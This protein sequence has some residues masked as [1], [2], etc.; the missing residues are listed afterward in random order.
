MDTEARSLGALLERR[1][2]RE[3]AT[4]ESENGGDALRAS[5]DPERR[6]SAS[7]LLTDARKTGNFLRQF[8]VGPGR[9]V[10]IADRPVPESVLA[11]FGTG[12]L[13]ATARFVRLDAPDAGPSMWVG[14]RALVAPTEVVGTV[15]TSAATNRVGYGSRPDDPE[16]AYFERDVWS[17][18]PTFPPSD[19]DGEA[20]AIEGR[21]GEYTHRE[22]IEATGRVLG[23]REIDRGTEL[24]VRAPL[25][26][27]RT[28]VAGILA[29]LAPGGTTLFPDA[30]TRGD[31]AIVAG[32]EED[33][34]EPASIDVTDVQPDD[35]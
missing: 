27:P 9:T 31:V 14:A 25:V 6:Y 34:P 35:G 33:V 1:A 18:N 29:P 28:V 21:G 23:E 20:I 22:L 16:V 24:A 7:R 11:L 2:D 4:A 10:A 3:E 17:E 15:S 8:G 5:G 26:D 30:E 19:V 13:G 32:E 12:L